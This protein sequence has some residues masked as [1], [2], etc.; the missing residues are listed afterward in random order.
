[1]SQ[2]ILVLT[3]SPRHNGNTSLLAD[4]FIDGAT[5]KGNKVT[6]IDVGKA[7][8]NGC[9]SCNFCVSHNGEC[10]LKDG[11]DEIYSQLE[12]AD[13]IVFV[14]PLYYYGFS[15]QLKAVID[16]FHAKSGVGKIK[17]SK[18]SIL[19]SAGADDLPAFN[20]LVKTYQA[21]LD[22]LKWEDIGILTI[23]KTEN[24]GDI[25]KTDGLIRAKSLG[26]SLN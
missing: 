10:A 19:L 21:I 24:K 2:N 11:M 5:S 1:M 9:T 7:K 20:P 6:R 16:R 15:A 18:K 26:T 12:L 3:G 23:E 13:I 25:N 14:T 17:P 4:S 22:Y 8:I